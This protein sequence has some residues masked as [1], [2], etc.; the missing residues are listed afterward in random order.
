MNELNLSKVVSESWRLFSENLVVILSVFIVYIIV[1]ILTSFLTA[2]VPEDAVGL[3]VI[4]NVIDFM[5]S[6]FLTAGLYRFGLNIIQGRDAAVGDLFSQSASTT[7]KLIGLSILVGLLVL[8]GFILLIVPGIILALKYSMV[9]QVLIDERVGPLEAMDKSSQLTSG[10]KLQLFLLGFINLGI[11][12]LG[13]LCFG[14][15]LLVAL[16]VT[17]LTTFVA[18]KMLNPAITDMQP[19]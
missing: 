9:F 7:L 14:I 13:A 8:V 2:A 18:Y 3:V 5:I 16:P 15:G 4:V 19:V 12:I 10:H 1:S 17:W 11:I 6:S